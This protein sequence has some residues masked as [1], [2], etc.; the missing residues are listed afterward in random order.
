MGLEIHIR[1]TRAGSYPFRSLDFE[2]SIKVDPAGPREIAILS[3]WIGIGTRGSSNFIDGP[4]FKQFHAP[5]GK[6]TFPGVGYG[7]I[8]IPLTSPVLETIERHRRGDLPI[9][10]QSQVLAAPVYEMKIDG[11]PVS[12]LGATYQTVFSVNGTTPFIHTI[13]H[14][15]WTKLLAQM[16]WSAL[17]LFEVPTEEFLSDPDLKRS[18]ELLREAQNRLLGGDWLGVLQ[19]CRQAF[20]AAAAGIGQTENKKSNFQKLIDRAGGGPK[21]KRLNDLVISLSAFCHLGRHEEF[22]TVHIT[23]EDA[24]A[25]LRCS[26][27]IF[28]LLGGRVD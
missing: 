9:S 18:I 13:P 23:R 14:S 16:K 8:S 20:E 24:R 15:D 6:A 19:N 22:P 17:E 12:I 28:A 25:A 2:C 5:F 21:S 7:V 4:Y 1:E 3:A 10:I 27:S 26:L 11:K